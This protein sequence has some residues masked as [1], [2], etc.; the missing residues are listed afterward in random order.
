MPKIPFNFTKNARDLGGYSTKS[1]KIVKPGKLIRSACVF[2]ADDYD[3][4]LL[5]NEYHVN[6]I[7]DF[8]N[9]DER[10]Q[11]PDVNIEGIET[12]QIPIFP[13]D[14]NGDALSRLRE[15]EKHMSFVRRMEI[16]YE[17]QPGFS[18]YELMKRNYIT[19]VS[20]PF[21]VSQFK[22]FLQ[23]VLE[24]D[25]DHTILYHCAGG[26]DRA[27]VA[28]VLLLALLG[29]DDD[30]IK[31]DYMLTGENIAFDNERDIERARQQTD[32]PFLAEI[33]DGCMNV[34][35]MYID[36]LFKYMKEKEGDLLSYIKKYFC[37][38][39]TEIA[40]LRNKYLV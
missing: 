7:I 29:V 27:G 8:R 36:E 33:L 13:D 40:Q 26:K 25:D 30:T 19:F 4:Y 18:I 5:L 22:K 1:G 20:D 14:G 17:T 10:N 6:K 39:D 28:T 2:M 24:E 11:T 9:P 32:R 16:V 35:D 15:D 37:I 23:I 12:I 21:C 3:R 34:K 38:T 31:Y